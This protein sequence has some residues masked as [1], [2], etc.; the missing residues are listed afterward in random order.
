MYHYKND[1]SNSQNISKAI[2]N[3]DNIINKLDLI[4]PYRRLHLTIKVYTFFSNLMEYLWKTDHLLEQVST[5]NKE[6]ASYRPL[7]L[8]CT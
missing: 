3:L 4:D 1:R 5:G 2:G 7:S 6:F 8:A